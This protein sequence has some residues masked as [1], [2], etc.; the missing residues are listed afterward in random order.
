MPKLSDLTYA[1]TLVMKLLINTRS[2]G[3]M[4]PTYEGMEECISCRSRNQSDQSMDIGCVVKLRHLSGSLGE[5]LLNCVISQYLP[6][7]VN[8]VLSDGIIQEN[9]NI[10]IKLFVLRKECIIHVLRSLY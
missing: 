6:V 1:H 8:L 7:S 4:V 10:S 3:H 2:V 5:C 9:N